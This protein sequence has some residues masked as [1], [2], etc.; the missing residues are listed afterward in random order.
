MAIGTLYVVQS[1]T[2]SLFQEAKSKSDWYQAMQDAGVSEARSLDAQ[3]SLPAW[4]Y[5]I[6]EAKPQGQLGRLFVGDLRSE[7]DLTGDPMVAFHGVAA[8]EAMAADLASMGELGLHTVLSASGHGADTWLYQ[9]LLQFL[10]QASARHEAVV[11][12]SGN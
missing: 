11:V 3:D 8:V 2:E 7:E 1:K 5:S 12:L 9:P 6:G 4:E 10:A